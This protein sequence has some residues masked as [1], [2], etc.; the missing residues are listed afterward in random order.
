M[1]QYGVAPD[2]LGVEALF[3]QQQSQQQQQLQMQMQPGQQVQEQLASGARPRSRSPRRDALA[4]SGSV[5]SQALLGDALG[6]QLVGFGAEGHV[7]SEFSFPSSKLGQLLG[8]RGTTIQK[9]KDVSGVT[10]LH[11]RDKERART[12]PTV[13]V[14]VQGDQAAVTHCTQLLES[15]VIG[16]QTAIG[17]LT[18]YLPVDSQ[19]IGK[20]MGHRGQTIKE[21]TDVTGCYMEIQQR[22]DQGVVDGQPRLFFAGEPDRVDHALNLAERFIASPGSRLDLVLTAEEKQAA[23]ALPPSSLPAASLPPLQAPKAVMRP[24]GGVG[25]VAQAL[26]NAVGGGQ[27]QQQQQQYTA[28]L[29]P[30]T[31]AFS[32][33]AP[34]R[35]VDSGGG[36]AAGAFTGAGDIGGPLEERTVEIPARFKGH[37]LGLRGQTIDTIRQLSGVSRCHMNERRGGDRNGMIPVEIVG[38]PSCVE[39]CVHLIRG[40]EAGDHTGLGHVTTYIPVDPANIGKLMGAKGQTIKEMTERTGCYMEIQQYPEQGVYDGQPKLFVV[41]PPEKVDAAANLI[42]RFVAAPGS[43]LET[44]LR[45]GELP[46]PN[47]PASSSPRPALQPQRRQQPQRGGVAPGASVADALQEVVQAAA[48]PGTNA[49]AAALTVVLNAVLRGAAGGEAPV[50]GGG[51]RQEERYVEIPANRRGHL[52]GLRGQTIEAVRQ[53]SGV[54]KCHMMDR[55]VANRPSSLSVQVVGPRDCVD[56]CASMI[57]RIVSGDHSCIGHATDS[58]SVDLHKVQGLIGPRGQT[59]TILKDLT[60]AYLDVQEGPQPGV[61]AGTAKVFMAGPPEKV[62]QARTVLMA[63]LTAMDH[64]PASSLGGGGAPDGAGLAQL[65]S[66]LGG[67]RR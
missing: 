56:R 57:R 38:E 29:P 9:L 60:G 49:V 63:F 33:Q 53:K 67:A 59:V 25:A 24:A 47:A 55:S 11:I 1:Q 8:V 44:V 50:G 5:G 17:H 3:Q 66:A 42:E 12:Q 21:M 20:L 43:R 58:L 37:L 31:P 46:L 45:P 18:T 41:G 15:L 39:A 32:S 23:P 27:R 16:D 7:T 34:A 62:Q 4:L 14:Q 51:G 52:L 26:L 28:A 10:R 65:L 48:A 30:R 2:P 36:L 54:A 19:L 6:G 35:A 22:E 61:P 13:P 64:L 40:V